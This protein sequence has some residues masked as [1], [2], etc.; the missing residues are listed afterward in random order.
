MA[1]DPAAALVTRARSGDPQAWRE[2]YERIG[3]RLIVWL[4]SQPH[5]DSSLDCEDIA[6]ESWFTAA[7]R[8]ADFRGDDDA[9]A[10][11][12]FGIARN[13]LLNANRRCYRRSTIPTSLDPR[14][15][16]PQRQGDPR[17]GHAEADQLAWIRSVLAQ[18]P[19]REAEVVACLDVVG[20]DVSGT[21]L[22][23]SM[24]ANAVR[25]RH[26]RALRRLRTLVATPELPAPELTMTSRQ[27]LG[28]VAPI[29]S[30]RP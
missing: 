22:A 23:L 21:A 7:N 14:V 30:V 12:L 15:L 25:V 8:I 17:D 6:N 20:L 1:V 9:F 3:G 26:H 2:L 4:R 24:S 16:L 18:L 29:R 10:G 5:A 19:P 27:P 11:W 28:S 13:H